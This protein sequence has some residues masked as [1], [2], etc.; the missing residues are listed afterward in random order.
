LAVRFDYDQAGWQVVARILDEN[1]TRLSRTRGGVSDTTTSSKKQPLL[2][3]G[4]ALR[5]RSA[6]NERRVQH[7]LFESRH[8]TA[9]R[10]GAALLELIWHVAELTNEELLPSPRMLR[11]WPSER[12]PPGPPGSR[13]NPA[14]LPE[15]LKQFADEVQRRWPELAQDPVPLASWAEWELNGGSL[16]PFYDGCG[17]IARS[18]GA[19]LLLRGSWLL[20]LYEDQETYFA[21]GHQGP[22][23][24]ADYVRQRIAVCARWTTC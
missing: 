2:L 23:V 12:L 3:Q 1:S 21:Q 15:A 13:T 4:E 10:D 16:H 6:E 7:F 18:F 5:R 24:F 17:R 11:A 19:L 14:E 9:P 20:P 8:E 22:A